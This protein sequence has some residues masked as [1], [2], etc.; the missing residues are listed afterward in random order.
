MNPPLPSVLP[1]LNED[2]MIDS[3]WFKV[4]VT[5]CPTGTHEGTAAVSLDRWHG[6]WHRLPPVFLD[7]VYHATSR[8]PIT[9]LILKRHKLTELPDNLSQLA[10]CLSEM[11]VSGNC[12]AKF[13]VVVCQ[14]ICLKELDMS[15]NCLSALPR[16]IAF[17]VNLR[18]LKL[19][20]NSF[21]EYPRGLCN[22]P[23]LEILNMECNALMY[24]SDEIGQLKQL[25]ELY[26][27]SNRIEQIPSS[28][29]C[30]M[31]LETLY[32][33]DN[34][35]RELPQDISNLVNLKQLHLAKNKLEHLPSSLAQLQLRGL[36]VA[37]N[38]LTCP[39][40]SVCKKGLEHIIWYLQDQDYENESQYEVAI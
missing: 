5:K 2:G 17:L 22:L 8:L 19:Q 1:Q 18:V 33:S 37:L 10:Q 28:L 16:D 36:T 7:S 32:L 9:A 4:I 25:K 29:C 21:S 20:H 13:P 30:L 15:T 11:D 40:V 14:L 27:K 3:N 31:H 35:L 39:P 23:A 26:L 24:L 12:F 38:P 6:L 34:N